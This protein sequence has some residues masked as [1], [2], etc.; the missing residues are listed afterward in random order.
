MCS[1]CKNKMCPTCRQNL[2]C[3]PAVKIRD[4]PIRIKNKNGLHFENCQCPHCRDFRPSGVSFQNQPQN[5]QQINMGDAGIINR[6]IPNPN[7]IN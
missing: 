6:V 4:Y 5:L 7:H 2:F 1:D 3:V